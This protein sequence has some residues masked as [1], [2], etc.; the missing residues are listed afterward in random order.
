MNITII[1]NKNI[2]VVDKEIKLVSVQDALDIIASAQYQCNCSGIIVYKEI[3]DENFFDLKTGFAGEVLQKF[4][5]YHLKLAIVGDFS[6]YTSKSLKDFIYESNKGN[7]V[8]FKDSLESA[9]SALVPE[10]SR[11]R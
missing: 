1:R 5:N 7:L 3:I 2:A 11:E 8:Y 9:L 4:S 10:K 6:N